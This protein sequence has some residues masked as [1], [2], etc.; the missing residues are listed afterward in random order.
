[1]LST[2]VPSITSSTTCGTRLWDAVDKACMEGFP[3][4]AREMGLEVLGSDTVNDRLSME[5]KDDQVFDVSLCS[6]S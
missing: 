1:M 2:M 3:D 4:L 6:Y 5:G